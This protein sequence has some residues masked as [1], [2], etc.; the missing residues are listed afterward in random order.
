MSDFGGKN[1]QNSI[2]AGAPPVRPRPI[3]GAYSAPPDLMAAF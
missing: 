1:A 2:S 3:W